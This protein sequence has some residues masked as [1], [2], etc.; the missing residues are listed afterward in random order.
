MF[1]GAIAASVLRTP[2]IR[3]NGC[4]AFFCSLRKEAK[5]YQNK[6]EVP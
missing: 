4:P 5:P 6:Q 1:I 2:G 3:S